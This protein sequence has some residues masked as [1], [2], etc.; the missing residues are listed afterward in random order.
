MKKLLEDYLSK[1]ITDGIN[2]SRSFAEQKI[3][4]NLRLKIKLLKN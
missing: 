4:L 2:S 3:Y 1:V